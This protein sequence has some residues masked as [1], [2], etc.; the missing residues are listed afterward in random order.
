MALRDI[1][2]PVKPVLALGR[3]INVATK[4]EHL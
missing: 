3:M 4:R 2:A 1:S